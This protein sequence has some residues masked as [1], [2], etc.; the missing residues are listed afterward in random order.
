MFSWAKPKTTVPA[1]GE[2]EADNAGG[3]FPSAVSGTVTALRENPRK[4]GRY[5]VLIEGKSVAIVN[6]A[7][8]HDSRLA[9]GKTISEADGERLL[10]A[11]R[12]LE[13]FDRAAAALGRRA[14]SAHELERWLL[15]RGFDRADVTDA[16]QRLTEIGAID[17]SQFARA[18]ARS[19]ALGKG[20]SKRRLAQE[21]SRRGVDR[22]Q[23][24]AAIAEVLEEE[25]VDE[26]ALLEAA[27]RKKLA[28]LGG[29]DADTVKR[30]LYG[31]LARRGYDAND[32][33]AVLRTVLAT[34]RSDA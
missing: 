31:Y 23:A 1:G 28:M 12:K 8:L 29:Q 22:Q 10:V 33:A 34:Y 30:R 2:D 6:A 4:P 11:A 13:A 32:I 25:S 27:A 14:R 26:R 18:F 3:H 16:V 24:D 19:R 7:Y 21:L 17:D 15:Q 9:V 5:A 20:M